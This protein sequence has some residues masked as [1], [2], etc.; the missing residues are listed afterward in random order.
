MLDLANNYNKALEEED[1]MTPEQVDPIFEEIT[2]PWHQIRPFDS[3]ACTV[4]VE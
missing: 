1:K 3:P 4:Q 2:R